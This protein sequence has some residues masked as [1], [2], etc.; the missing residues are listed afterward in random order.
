MSDTRKIDP[1]LVWRVAR[2]T[3]G[4]M[5]CEYGD[6]ARDEHDHAICV[7]DDASYAA[8][9]LLRLVE[10]AVNGDED[11]VLDRMSDLLEAVGP[12]NVR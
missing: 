10:P 11:A 1:A 12:D 3:L 5:A 7:R 2:N 9:L 6:P 8:D 4:R